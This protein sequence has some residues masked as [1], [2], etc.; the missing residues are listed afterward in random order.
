MRNGFGQQT[1]IKIGS[2]RENIIVLTIEKIK[3]E[4][5]TLSFVYVTQTHTQI[6]TQ[7]RLSESLLQR[8]PSN[9]IL[10]WCNASHACCWLYYAPAV[11]N[12]IR[13]VIVRVKFIMLYKCALPCSVYGIS[14]TFS[15]GRVFQF[16]GLNSASAEN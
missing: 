1:L 15:Q 9:N 11:K 2:Y 12:S 3:E 14:Y 7:A 16:R 10:S 13:V 6:Q 5:N 8:A 4:G